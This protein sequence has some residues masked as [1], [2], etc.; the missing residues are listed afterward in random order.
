MC[1]ANVWCGF[2]GVCERVHRWAAMSTAGQL[3]ALA[4]KDL[5]IALRSKCRTLIELLIPLLVVPVLL[6]LF[7][8]SVSC[9]WLCL[10]SNLRFV[11]LEELQRL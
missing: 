9:L 6:G 4:R 3:A 7:Y 8:V 11:V 2:S 5:Q 10:C 1:C